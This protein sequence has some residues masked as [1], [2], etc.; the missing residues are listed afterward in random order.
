MHPLRYIFI[1]GAKFIMGLWCQMIQDIKSCQ[2]EVKASKSDKQLQSYG[3]LKIPITRGAKMHI[4]LFTIENPINFF[5]RTRRPFPPPCHPQMNCCLLYIFHPELDQGVG[6]ATLTLQ[7]VNL[8]ID[9][10]ATAYGR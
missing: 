8:P 2:R 4:I 5:M 10:I 9:H 3:H 1:C 6:N 7:S